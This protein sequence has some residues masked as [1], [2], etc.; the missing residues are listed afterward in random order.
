LSKSRAIREHPRFPWLWA[1]EPEGVERFLRS[2]SWIEPS[3][4]FLGCEKAGEGNMNLALRVR[5]CRRSVVL[6][7][8]RPWVEKYEEIAAPWGRM[9]QE[10]RYYERVACIPEVA[11]RTPKL[12]ASDAE[13]CAILLED[14]APC[15][16]L[17]L[18]YLGGRIED[19]EVDELASYLRALHEAATGADLA[20]FENRAMRELNHAHIFELPLTSLERLNLD[21]FEPGLA[22]AAA[23]VRGDASLRTRIA[24]LGR[25]YLSNGPSLIHGDFFPGS[26]LRSERGLFVID[27]EFSHAGRPEFDV[28]VAAAHLALGRQ[29]AGVVHRFLERY[30]R[31]AAGRTLDDRLVASFAGVE[32]IRRIMGVAQLPIPKSTGFR[33]ELL[34]R[35]VRV[36]SGEPLEALWD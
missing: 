13:A 17:S 23:G 5:T 29:P 14:L 20:A 30:R 9:D 15:R 28:G 36:L 21:G 8:A 12:L 11:S 1:G 19:E 27:A 26:W 18:L 25:A 22:R 4:G 32:I 16:D 10:R 2:R 7:Q 35:A 31:D 33:V 6:K 24:E 34:G 3:E